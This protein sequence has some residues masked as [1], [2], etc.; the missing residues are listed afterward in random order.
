MSLTILS[1]GGARDMIEKTNK[2]T[3]I[4]CYDLEKDKPKLTANLDTIRTLTF[5]ISD[6]NKRYITQICLHKYTDELRIN[7][8]SD[9][10]K[11]EV[12]KAIKKE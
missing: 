10:T 6:S 12:E 8:F 3:K 5:T 9:R 4:V 7:F 2:P 11:V 1:A